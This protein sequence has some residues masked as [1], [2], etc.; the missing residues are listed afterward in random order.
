M[1]LR[2]PEEVAPSFV[3][4]NPRNAGNTSRSRRQTGACFDGDRQDI[5]IDLIEAAEGPHA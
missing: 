4:L 1:G 3:V 5:T 2:A